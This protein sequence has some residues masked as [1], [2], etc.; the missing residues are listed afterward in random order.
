MESPICDHREKADAGK[1]YKIRV[2]SKFQLKM[3][4]RFWILMMGVLPLFMTAQTTASFEELD[5]PDT[6]FLD[7]SDNSGGFESGH[8][9]LPNEYNES[10]NFWT[11]WAISASTDTT[12]PG[13]E[14]QYSSISGNG[15]NSDNYAVSFSSSE[16]IVNLREEAE[17][18]PVLGLWVNN[19]TYAYLS[20]Q[21]GDAFAKKFGGI[22]G[23]DPDYF[24]L[25]IKKYQNGALSQDSVD[26][27]LADYRFAEAES[28]Y[29]INEWTYVDLT[30]L[31]DVDSLSL[32]LSSTDIGAFGMNTP[33]YFCID[34]LTTA[35]GPSS[36]SQIVEIQDIQ[37]YPNPATNFIH[38]KAHEASKGAYKIYDLNGSMVMNGNLMVGKSV[39]ISSLNKG[40]YIFQFNE[41]RNMSK[42]LFLKL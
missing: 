7:G 39:D 5:V 16:N 14:N 9:F 38:L 3:M 40:Q 15:Y 29:I 27:Y 8:I 34:D 4:K 22:D 2:S 32:S 31:G 30:S 41:G 19:S 13:F 1:D 24:L 18:N 25:T 23:S 28:D 42:A 36:T 11:G 35:D 20:M 33:A 26:F 10:Y 17:G 12:T 21:D 6:G 37:I